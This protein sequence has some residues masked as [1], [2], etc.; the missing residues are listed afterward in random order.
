MHSVSVTIHVADGN[1]K[2]KQATVFLRSETNERYKL[3]SLSGLFS[4]R[5]RYFGSYI[6]LCHVSRWQRLTPQAKTACFTSTVY[7]NLI[8]NSGRNAVLRH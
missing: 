1:V 4:Y 3:P 8:P 5:I 2:M 7:Q 6:T